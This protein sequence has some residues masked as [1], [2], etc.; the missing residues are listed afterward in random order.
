MKLYNH[1]FSTNFIS[2]AKTEKHECC[3]QI[4][5]DNFPFSS[6]KV[7]PRKTLSW[8]LFEKASKQQILVLY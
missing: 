6:V 1:A 4:T 5:K 7:G 3:D 2:N 8:R